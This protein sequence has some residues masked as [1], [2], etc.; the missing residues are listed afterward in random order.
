M[1]LTSSRRARRR[2]FAY[3]FIKPHAGLGRPAFMR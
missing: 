3:E 1:S 2:A